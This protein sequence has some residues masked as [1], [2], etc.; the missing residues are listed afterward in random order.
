[1]RAINK[2]CVAMQHHPRWAQDP[3]GLD[4]GNSSVIES[5]EF[6][7]FHVTDKCIV[8]VIGLYQRQ[9]L[10]QNRTSVKV[11]IES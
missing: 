11:E 7:V 9:A 3:K 4:H 2:G 10:Y 8:S 5:F 1:L 6:W